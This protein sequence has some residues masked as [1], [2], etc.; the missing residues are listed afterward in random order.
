MKKKI[1]G[2]R[3]FPGNDTLL[4]TFPGNEFSREMGKPMFM[5]LRVMEK[6]GYR[7]AKL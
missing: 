1:S 6:L 7:T 2:S 5:H 3:E 4:P